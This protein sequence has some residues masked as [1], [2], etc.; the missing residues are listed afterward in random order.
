MK[1]LFIHQNFPGQ[2]KHLAP[3]L[4]ARGDRVKALCV[5]EVRAPM[6]GVDIIRYPI[7]RG[8]A[9]NI[10]PWAGEFE[11]KIIRGEAC[12][13]AM[14]KL[15]E[16]GFIPDIILAHPGWGE[17]MFAK[18][19]FPQAKLLS[20]I[21]YYYRAQGQDVNFDKEF[22]KRKFEDDAR[23][24]TKNANNLMALETMDHGV[25]PTAW[26]RDTNPEIFRSRISVIHDG[27]D[28]DALAPNPAAQFTVPDGGPVLKAG[29]EV[30]TFVNRNLEPLRGFHIFMRSLPSIQAVRPNAHIVIVGAD[31]KGYGGGAGGWKERM[32]NELGDRVDRSKLHFVGRTTYPNFVALLQVSRAHVYLTYPFVLSWSMIEA[33][34]LGCVVVGS[35]T[36]PVREVITDGESGLLVDFFD[37]EGLAAKVSDVLARPEAYLEMRRKARAV[38]VERY[39][40]RRVCL[41]AQLALIDDLLAGRSG[42][43]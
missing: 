9:P 34:S 31:G 2:Y 8:S 5:S 3:A 27:V 14:R 35:G 24:I 19:V 22:G 4:A 20:F 12:A 39:D 21:E 6:P 30:V 17:A 37:F 41:P 16:Q 11:T 25:S 15:K 7:K 1:A 38:A 32:L 43:D 42:A 13:H 23:T 18:E 40:L 28:T 33:M 36:A 29:D 26:Q 10:H